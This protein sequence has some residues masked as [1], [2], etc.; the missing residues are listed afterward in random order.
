MNLAFCRLSFGQ[1]ITFSL[2]LMQ[3]TNAINNTFEIFWILPTH[4][5]EP[6]GLPTETAVLAVLAVPQCLFTTRITDAKPHFFFRF[7]R[8][9][10][11]YIFQFS[12]RKKHTKQTK[13]TPEQVS[14]DIFAVSMDSVAD[15]NRK[16]R[17]HRLFP[18]LRNRS[19]TS[20]CTFLFAFL[21]HSENVP[22]HFRTSTRV[23]PAIAAV[24][25]WRSHTTLCNRSLNEKKRKYVRAIES[26]S[27][28]LRCQPRIRWET[29]HSFYRKIN[30]IISNEEFVYAVFR[31][32]A[33]IKPHMEY[34]L[35]IVIM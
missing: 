26:V 9:K 12:S 34:E 35:Q 6:V 30:K 11:G 3:T 21:Q 4:L 27:L 32:R 20:K 31:R 23:T 7:L 24:L 1:T 18:R 33:S 16:T 8:N 17:A 13:R 5:I 22:W 15:T 10:I 2:S 29:R 28:S 14:F 19:K 25:D